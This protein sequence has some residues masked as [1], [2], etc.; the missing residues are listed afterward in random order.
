MATEP[1][2]PDRAVALEPTKVIA[3]PF[4]DIMELL[5]QKPDLIAMLV[6]IFCRAFKEAHVEVNSLDTHDMVHRL[7]KVLL[8]LAPKIGRPSGSLVEISTYLT[9]EEI[10]QMIAARR[11]TALNS[12]R[13]R[14]VLHLG[15]H[16]MLDVRAL[17]S[18]YA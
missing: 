10:A 12:L 17:E 3:V 8:G 11:E 2:R 18:H 14:G 15:G 13:R 5:R 4:E 16:L 9:Q 1:T 6:D 7:S